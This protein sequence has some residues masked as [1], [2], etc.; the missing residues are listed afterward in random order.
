[1]GLST[2]STGLWAFTKPAAA[3]YNKSVPSTII[4]LNNHFQGDSW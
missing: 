1:M 2:S 4:F 3:C